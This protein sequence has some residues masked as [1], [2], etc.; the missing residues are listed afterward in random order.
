MSKPRRYQRSHWT[1]LGQSMLPSSMTDHE[2]RR[3][4]NRI[5]VCAGLLLALW[6]AFFDS[7]SL[8]KRVTW[9]QEFTELREE[10]ARLS[11]EIDRL[12]EEVIKGLSDEAVEEIAREEYGMRRLGETVYR[13]HRTD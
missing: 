6:L 11:T 8:L 7:H 2:K 4:R 13:V 5:L 10:N 1:R 3:L 12:E 9:H